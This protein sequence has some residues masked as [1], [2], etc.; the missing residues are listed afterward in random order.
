MFKKA[1]KKQSRLRLALAGPSGSGK[2]FGALAIAKGLGGKVAVLDTERGS[3]SLYADMFDFDVVELGP[4]YTPER[5][6]DIINAAA[7]EG[8]DTLILDSITHEWSGKGGILEIVDNVAKT[9]Y[10]GNSYAAWNKATPRHQKFVDAM[11]ASPLNIIATMRSKTV[12]VE[13]EKPNGKKTIEKQGTA[14]QQRDGLEYEFTVVLD[15]AIDGHLAIA[16][17]DRTRLF[18]DP[19]V[20][21]PEVGQRLLAWLNSG[22]V[23]PTIEQQKQYLVQKAFVACCQSQGINDSNAFHDE[24]TNFFGREVNNSKELTIDEMQD[25]IDAVT[26]TQAEKEQN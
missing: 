14:P 25:Y 3:A 15:V 11:L 26:Q 13:T 17:K 19:F 1:E 21:T 24:M 12:Y 6:I 4:D 22:A 8:Y 7:K 16:S 5:Y 9:E 20:I 10:R 18:T 2:T 23:N